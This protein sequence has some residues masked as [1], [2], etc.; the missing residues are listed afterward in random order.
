MKK[1]FFLI[2]AVLAVSLSVTAKETAADYLNYEL[3]HTK[4][5]ILKDIS[6]TDWSRAVKQTCADAQLYGGMV[7]YKRERFPLPVT[8]TYALAKAEQRT[9]KERRENLQKTMRENSLWRL[10]LISVPRNT[11]L[12]GRTEEQFNFVK[13]FFKQ[14]VNKKAV[15]N[16][17]KKLPVEIHKHYIVKITLQ[18]DEEHTHFLFVD[19]FHKRVHFVSGDLTIENLPYKNTKPGEEFI[20]QW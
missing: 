10:F 9:F 19:C 5:H 7:Q 16:R 1:G 6:G 14:P 20:T 11:D 4:Q 3:E 12:T 18:E 8:Q 17:Y 15:E 13:D 2:L